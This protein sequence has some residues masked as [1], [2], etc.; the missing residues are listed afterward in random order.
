MVLVAGFV[1]RLVP[2]IKCPGGSRYGTNPGQSMA[3]S[4]G[5]DDF[6]VSKTLTSDIN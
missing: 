3:S 1:L 5:L 2:S 6:H 4:S